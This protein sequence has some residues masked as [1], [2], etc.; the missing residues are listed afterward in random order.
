MKLFYLLVLNFFLCILGTSVSAQTNGLYLKADNLTTNASPQNNLPYRDYAELESFQFGAEHPVSRIAGQFKGDT[1]SFREIT[2]TQLSNIS[3]NPFMSRMM[4]ATS[5]SNME[6]INL[7]IDGKGTT[8]VSYKVEL[9]DI[10]IT[11]GTT[12][13]SEEGVPTDSFTITYKA[14][15]ITTYSQNSLGN[16]NANT[17]FMFNQDTQ[18]GDFN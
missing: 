18:S 5:I 3:S 12:V 6:F 13:V 15:K 14:V 10:M 7:R 9:K 1:P 11:S 17:P 8:A 2:F 16:Y 4:T